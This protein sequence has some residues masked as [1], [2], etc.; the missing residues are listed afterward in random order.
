MTVYSTVTKIMNVAIDEAADSVAGSAA[1][2]I[3]DY[4]ESLDS[5]N[6]P[7]ISISHSS[8]GGYMSVII[9]SGK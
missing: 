1:K 2:E 8:A 4:I 9:V 7:I 3:N 6:S 5:T